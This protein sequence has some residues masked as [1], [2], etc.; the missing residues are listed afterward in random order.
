MKTAENDGDVEAFL[1]S[2]SNRGRAEDAAV[3]AEMMQRITGC[4]PRMW[5]D[6]IIGFDGYD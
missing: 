1:A 3:V 2:V 6:S 5:G 4:P